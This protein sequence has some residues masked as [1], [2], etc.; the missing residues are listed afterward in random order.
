MT[1]TQPVPSVTTTMRAGTWRPTAL[2][3][4]VLDAALAAPEP[5][6]AAFDE[7]VDVTDFDDVDAG[8][9]RLLPLVAAR[10]ESD[11]ITGPWSAHLRGIL[12]RSWYENQLLLHGALPAADAL[13]ERGIDVVVLKGGSLATSAYPSIGARPMDDLD[14]LVPEDRAV[15][16]LRVLLDA[17]WQLK[18]ENVPRVMHRGEIPPAFRR[19]RHGVGMSGPA[20]F[21]IDLHWH[22]TYAWCWP[23]ADRG[24]WA[25]TRP[26]ELGGRKLLALA[27]PD[28]LVVACIHGLMANLVAPVRWVTDASLVIRTE[29]FDWS[30]LVGRARELEVEPSLG[31]ALQYLCTRFDACV[32]PWVQSTLAERH[33]GYFEREWLAARTELRTSRTIGA[34]YGAYLRSARMDPV[35]RRYV[36]GVPG[37]VAALLG[38]ESIPELGTQLAGRSAARVKRALSR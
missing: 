3:E 16:A 32:P 13:Q 37:Y 18:D 5:A 10:F 1:Q 28:E 24:L 36:G 9:F 4:L 29:G 11:G 22:A 17:G 14:L 25:T 8:S 31:V 19:L 30:A 33:P 7:W 34:H 26:L 6:V 38:C 21:D 12:R 23:G 2:Q 20:G 27:A 35:L 15:D